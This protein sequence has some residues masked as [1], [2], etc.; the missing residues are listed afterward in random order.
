MAIEPNPKIEIQDFG[1][2][3]EG[4]IE[5]KPL[6]IF[7]GPNNSGK[8]YGA[9]LI[10][11]L[12]KSFYRLASPYIYTF[13]GQEKRVKEIRVDGSFEHEEDIFEKVK[14]EI[15]HNREEYERTI[16]ELMTE[17]IKNEIEYSYL[18]TVNN[19]ARI[20]KKSFRIRMNNN[21]YR[22]VIENSNNNLKK[23]ECPPIDYHSLDVGRISRGISGVVSESQHTV[24]SLVYTFPNILMAL[25]EE[26]SQE[27]CKMSHYLPAA[28]SGIL[29]MYR[30]FMGEVMRDIPRIRLGRVEVPRLS[31]V[32]SDF[33]ATL[34]EIQDSHENSLS[35][36]GSFYELAGELE[37]EIMRGHITIKKREKYTYPEIGYEYLDSFIPLHM[38]SSTISELAPLVL[39]LKYVVKPGDTL[40]IEEPEAHLHPLNQNIL[41]KYLVKLI[42]M[43]VHLILTTHSEFLL[44]KLGNFIMLSSI[45]KEKRIAKYGYK[46]EDY[47]LPEEISVHLFIP[48][49]E[50]KNRIEK[51]QITGE[52]GISQEEFLKVHESLY[53]ETYKLY[54]DIENE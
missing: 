39:Y 42:R 37:K 29:Q 17:E 31:G 5:I 9:M 6:T 25:F 41:A 44:E 50:G 24:S 7:I 51:A 34:L 48:D 47:L 35:R 10:H 45:E 27:F 52:E 28:R 16:E 26:I 19:I 30:P 46:E 20:G 54:M 33:M 14:E 15:S 2:I 12:Y 40:I 53:D 32:L 49:Q 11:S 8:S 18:S 1:P 13:L 22:F 4:V 38:A 43:K 23:I 3:C 21:S 36:E